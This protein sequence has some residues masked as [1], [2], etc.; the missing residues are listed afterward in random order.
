[1]VVAVEHE[2]LAAGRIGEQGEVVLYDAVVA[3]TFVYVVA[4]DGLEVLSYRVQEVVQFFPSQTDGGEAVVHKVL[5]IA[6]ALGEDADHLSVGIEQRRTQCTCRGC[7]VQVAIYADG[8]RAFNAGEGPL[9]ELGHF[10]SVWTGVEEHRAFGVS[11][12][13]AV[14]TAVVQV[15]LMAGGFVEAQEHQAGSFVVHHNVCAGD[16][17]GERAFFFFATGFAVAVEFKEQGAG[18][19]FQHR[20]AGEHVGLLQVA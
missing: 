7:S 18:T 20:V 11:R 4:V 8:R 2:H 12:Y 9:V 16:H 1:M 19:S 13:I 17:L 10:E 3:R 14:P 6:V 15:P 5:A